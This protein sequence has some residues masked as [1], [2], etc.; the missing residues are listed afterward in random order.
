MNNLTLHQ[1]RCFDAVVSAGSFQAAANVLSRSQP[2]VFA[3]VKSLEAQVGVTLLDRS[4]YRVALTDVG[5]SFHERARVFL[6]EFDK[7]DQHVTQLSMGRETELRVVIGDLCPIPETLS[8][9]RRFFNDHPETRLHLYFEAISGPLEKL[10]QGEADLM[11]HHI[12]QT[13]PT[14]DYIRL[15]TVQLIPVVAPGFLSFPIDSE[16]TPTQMR[17]YVQCIIRDSSERPTSP[18]Y[19]LV[20][21]ARQCT[22]SDQLM[23]KEIILQGMGWGHMP[24]FMIEQDIHNGRLLPIIGRHM[25]GGS[26]ELVAARKRNAPHG[27]VAQHLWQ[28]IEGQT[29]AEKSMA[30]I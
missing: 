18:D 21:G 26:V 5:R 27:P 15:N 30:E 1:L 9:L 29:Q 17:D 8:L 3:A 16:I 14:I 28:Y 12:D 25:R 22:V 20:E 13:D 11:F 10:N 23:K 6:H 7:L 2:T 19:Y 24:D 4:A